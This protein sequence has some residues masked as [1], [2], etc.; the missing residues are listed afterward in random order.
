MVLYLWE[1]RGNP[2]IFFGDEK[3]WEKFEKKNR[4]WQINCRKWQINCQSDVFQFLTFFAK[5]WEKII[6]KWKINFRKW[7]INC[8]SDV[9]LL[10]SRPPS[11]RLLSP[12][13]VCFFSPPALSLPLYP[14]PPLLSF[15]FVLLSFLL[16]LS[17]VLYTFARPLLLFLN[18][19]DDYLNDSSGII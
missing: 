1:I 7:E 17:L 8:Q 15:L 2:G 12:F 5:K 14:P 6:R 10:A 3:S 16:F 9:P 19:F 4:K 18:W 11:P 13:F